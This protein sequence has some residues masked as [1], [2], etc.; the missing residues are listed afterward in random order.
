MATPVVA[1]PLG[2]ALSASQDSMNSQTNE[3]TIIQ[4][5][6]GGSQTNINQNNSY[7]STYGFG[8]GISCP[9][10]S[11]GGAAFTGSS[12]AYAGGFSS[13]A[14]TFGGGVGFVIPLGGSIG[15]SCK[16]LAA[17]IARQRTLDTQVTLIKTCV[18]LRN[19]GVV[20]D[21]TKLPEFEICDDI[22]YLDNTD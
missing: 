20:V 9:T 8:I 17:E 12:N 3:G 13:D 10:A 21:T 19:L 15:E 2:Q 16:K 14:T 22:A 11:I 5:P 7:N 4:A 1:S 6:S 18:E